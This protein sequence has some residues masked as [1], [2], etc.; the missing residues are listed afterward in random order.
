MSEW[1]TSQKLSPGQGTVGPLS[2]RIHEEYKSKGFSGFMSS[3]EPSP[4]PPHS[5]AD[6]Q[7][8]PATRYLLFIPQKSTRITKSPPWPKDGEGEELAALDGLEHLGLTPPREGRVRLSL[9]GMGLT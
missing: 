2:P 7:D 3:E 9:E 1:P 5:S 6:W 4:H 8:A